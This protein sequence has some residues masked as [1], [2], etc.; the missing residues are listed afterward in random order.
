MT[1]FDGQ[2][3]NSRDDHSLLRLDDYP[4]AGG[5]TK[6]SSNRQSSVNTDVELEILSD[7][8][9]EVAADIGLFI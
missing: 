3:V 7:C 8:L 1:A 2:L 5:E 4:V 9:E 6:V